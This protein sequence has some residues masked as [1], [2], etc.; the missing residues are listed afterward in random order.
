MRV[1]MLTSPSGKAYIG[2]TKRTVEWRW[3]AHVQRAQRGQQHPLYAAVRKYGPDVFDVRE[4]AVGLTEEQAKAE[5]IRLIAELNT[6][7]RN[8]GYNISAGGDYDAAAGAAAMSARLADPKFRAEYLQKLSTVKLENDW[9]DYPALAAKALAWRAANPRAAYAQARRAARIA[10]RAAGREW[11]GGPRPPAGSF[12]RLFIRSERATEGRR[13]YFSTR[14]ARAL[15]ARRDDADKADVG[16]KIAAKRRAYYAD[17]SNYATTV[18]QLSGARSKIDRAKQGAAASA[19]LKKYWADLK[20]DP[21]RYA[22]VMERKR[23]NLR[24]NV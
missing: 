8:C 16:A 5:E 11:T 1:Y 20:A 21:G 4:L 15:W 17:P 22:E 7:D 24:K 12:G 23:A 14:N 3:A 18:Q 19:G 6:Q 10:A 2:I 9:S 13:A